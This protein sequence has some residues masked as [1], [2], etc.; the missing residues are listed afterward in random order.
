MFC[1]LAV[2]SLKL[3]FN[4][5]DELASN[6]DY[7]FQV[8]IGTFREQIFKVSQVVD[9]LVKWTTLEIGVRAVLYRFPDS[10]S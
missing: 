8:R 4:N 5:L 1:L 7:F 3:P 10:S 6:D 2:K 9:H